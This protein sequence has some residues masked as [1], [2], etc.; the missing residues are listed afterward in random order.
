MIANAYHAPHRTHAEVI[1]KLRR[2]GAR[3]FLVSDAAHHTIIF[4]SVI[5][6]QLPLF[7]Q[8]LL[9]GYTCTIVGDK[10]SLI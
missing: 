9:C 5:E 3:Y 4:P 2:D 10:C 7:E 6:C 1:K 8:A